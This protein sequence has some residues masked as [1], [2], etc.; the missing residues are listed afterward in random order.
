[1]NCYFRVVSGDALPNVTDIKY[2]IQGTAVHSL[3]LCFHF[4]LTVKHIANISSTGD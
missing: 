2:L 3:N 4:H 1:M